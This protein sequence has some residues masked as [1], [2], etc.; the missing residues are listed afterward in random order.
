MVTNRSESFSHALRH[1]ETCLV[2]QK[3]AVAKAETSDDYV[4]G[5]LQVAKF[6][7]RQNQRQVAQHSKN[8]QTRQA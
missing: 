1:P 7:H 2:E 3:E 6:E 5:L 4:V 8:L